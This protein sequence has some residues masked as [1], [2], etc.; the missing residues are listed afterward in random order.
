ME[1]TESWR[2]SVMAQEGFSKRDK[3][4]MFC[5]CKTYEGLLTTGKWCCLFVL[6]TY[7]V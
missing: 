5:T 7:I 1:G 3:G 4:K 2:N 6:M